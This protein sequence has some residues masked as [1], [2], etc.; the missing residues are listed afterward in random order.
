MEE[1]ER[2]CTVSRFLQISKEKRRVIKENKT[3]G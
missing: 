1:R 2:E 3:I